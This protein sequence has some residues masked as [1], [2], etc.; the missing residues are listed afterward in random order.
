MFDGPGQEQGR[1]PYEGVDPEPL[2]D[3]VALRPESQML[4]VLEWPERG[5]SLGL[6]AVGREDFLVRPAVAVGDE[7]PLAEMDF[8]SGPWPTGLKLSWE[9]LP[10]L[11][12]VVSRSRGWPN[13]SPVRV[14]IWS[15]KFIK[16]DYLERFPSNTLRV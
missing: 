11:K 14:D 8:D 16:S 5:F 12:T 7:H 2:V 9:L 3:P 13:T 6:A 15:Q 10:W 4:V 1:Q